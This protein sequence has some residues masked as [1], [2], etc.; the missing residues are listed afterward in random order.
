MNPIVERMQ[1]AQQYL[2]RAANLEETGQ[3]AL[4]ATYV[5]RAGELIEETRTLVAA[6]RGPG[7]ATNLAMERAAQVVVD[8]YKN[9]WANLKE[10]LRPMAEAM[11]AISEATQADYVLASPSKGGSS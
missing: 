9:V 8:H 1:R 3:P 2:E 10:A 4:C 11:R 7:F 6:H 5:R